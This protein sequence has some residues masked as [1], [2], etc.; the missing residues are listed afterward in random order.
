MDNLISYSINLCNVCSWLYK[1]SSHTHTVNSATA[2]PVGYYPVPMFVC[3]LYI[4][5][6]V[7]LV[8]YLIYKR[9]AIV[10]SSRFIMSTHCNMI[11]IWATLYIVP[12]FL[13]NILGLNYP[14]PYIFFCRIHTQQMVF[15]VFFIKW[16]KFLYFMGIAYGTRLLQNAGERRWGVRSWESVQYLA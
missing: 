3:I 10:S 8:A 14:S 2:H 12:F 13:Y 5:V 9:V 4:F 16:S 7:K 15:S 11:I 6:Y 1:P